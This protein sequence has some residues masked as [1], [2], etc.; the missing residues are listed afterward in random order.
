MLVRILPHSVLFANGLVIQKP[1]AKR[2]RIRT[3]IKSTSVWD[4]Q[5]AIRSGPFKFW[6]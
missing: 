1:S 2:S 4:F 5:M 6:G 3:M